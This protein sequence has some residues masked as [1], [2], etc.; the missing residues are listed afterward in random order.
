VAIASQAE[1]GQI[2][3]LLDEL[4]ALLIQL[5]HALLG[6]AP[7]ANEADHSLNKTAKKGATLIGLAA[8]FVATEFVD[9]VISSM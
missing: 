9:N 5:H 8:E 1:R 7:A 6:L 3:G 2:L 4:L